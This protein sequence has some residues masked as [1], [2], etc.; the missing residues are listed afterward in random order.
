MCFAWSK[1]AI[2]LQLQSVMNWVV[3]LPTDIFDVF[4]DV[5]VA[6]LERI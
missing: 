3:F 2:I 5:I 4:V 6:N 1:L